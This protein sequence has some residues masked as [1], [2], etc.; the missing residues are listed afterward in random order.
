[1]LSVVWFIVA[2]SVLVAA[3]EFGHFWVARRLG[4]K[5]L[6][7]SI[8]FGRPLAVWRSRHPDGTE[9]W[10]S[11]IPLGGYVKMLDEREAAV[12]EADRGRAFNQRPI[13]H[14]IAVLLAGPA[15]NFLFA[16][17]AYW[18]MFTS[19]V[20]GLKAVIG[21][22]QPDSVAAR[23]G[24]VAGDE[25]T[26]VG[27]RPT[28][29]WENATLR[30][31][32]Q[33]LATARIDL[34]V[35]EPDGKT[36]NVELDV[37]GRESELTEPAALYTGLGLLPGPVLPAV[38]DAVTPDS[39]AAAAGLEAGDEVV[40]IG[41]KPIR[42]W[43][44]WVNQIKQRPGETVDIA[45]R[46]DGGERTF[47]VAI[48]TVQEAGKTIGRIGASRPSTLP[49]GL[50]DSLRAEQRYG[51]F[52]SLPRG[53]E[54]TWEMSALTVRMLV[55]MVV[56][57]VSL[58]NMSGPLTIADYA[59][60]SA[61]AGLAPFLSFLA[62]VSISLGILNLLPIPMLDGGQVVYQIAEWFKGSPLSERAL[63]LGQQIGVFFLIVLMSFAFYNDL[64]RI[65]GS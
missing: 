14:R 50:M 17:V 10:L 29:T 41:D 61:Q 55:R 30:I 11:M 5:V 22:V 38:I 15:F 7:F 40:A 43:D 58:K 36:R 31:F 59:G 8:G 13:P 45:V 1:M 24:I 4:F 20:P 60:E 63:V 2:I 19:G 18:L 62:A 12:P 57:D 27:G 48:G 34:T 3:H 49:P 56:G 35:R 9:Y 53:V 26:A 42:S 47:S 21:A 25:I 54:K 44:Q 46:R 16:I 51:V 65:F 32:D 39:P 23:A 37:R 6:R 33:L 52:E 64:S 28:S